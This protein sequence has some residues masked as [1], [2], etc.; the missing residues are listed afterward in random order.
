MPRRKC[1]KRLATVQSEQPSS[2]SAFATLLCRS[3][4]QVLLED[5]AYDLNQHLQQ[6]HVAAFWA[7]KCLVVFK[8]EFQRPLYGPVCHISKAKFM[9]LV[10]LRDMVPEEVQASNNHNGHKNYF[11]MVKHCG[12]ATGELWQ[13][14]MVIA[15]AVETLEFHVKKIELFLHSIIILP[16][17][18]W[19][20]YDNAHP[21]PELALQEIL[22][23]VCPE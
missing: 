14:N 10:A 19:N 5:D 12:A 16:F 7:G 6:T 13:I 21:L 3:K 20:H 4:T 2:N 15:H 17:L 22:S 18:M 9:N 8:M 23:L 11:D 1:K